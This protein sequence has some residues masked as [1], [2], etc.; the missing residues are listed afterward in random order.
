M[1]PVKNKIRETVLYYNPDSDPVRTSKLKGVLVSMKI[2]IRNIGL[3]QVDK[4]IGTLVGVD[5]FEDDMDCT[6]DQETM[7]DH[8]GKR[9]DLD[10]EM[11]V[12]FG[13]TSRRIDE[14]LSRLR[15]SG[16][17]KI[18]LK[19]VVT[20][21]NRMWTFRRLYGELK[22]EHEKMTQSIQ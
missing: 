15:K 10:Q 9:T 20:E 13:F 16:V 12:M 5:S 21:D 7:P 22:E 18:A 11:L 6:R 2:R 4:T 19:A 3:D 1:I 17:S 8:D 14:L